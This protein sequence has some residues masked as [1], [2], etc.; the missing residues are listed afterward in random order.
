LEEA[1]AVLRI[2]EPTAKRWWAYARA[3]LFHE[4]SRERDGT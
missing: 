3:W 2:S 4:I 1:A